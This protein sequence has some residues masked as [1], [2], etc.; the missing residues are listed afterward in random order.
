MNLPFVVGSVTV[1]VIVVLGWPTARLTSRHASAA[2]AT[3]PATAGLAVAV[4]VGLCIL[5]GTSL[6]P[7]LLLIAL[8]G[9]AVYLDARRRGRLVTADDGPGNLALVVAI[10]VALLPVLLVDVPAV[11]SDARY[12]WW[13]HAGWFRH[14]GDVTRSGMTEPL[15]QFSRSR[16]PPVLPGVIA[17]VWHVVDAYGSETALRVSQLFTVAAV[18]AAGFHTAAAARLRG[19]GAA[20]LA[21]V[22]VGVGWGANAQVGLVGFADLAWSSLFVAGAVLLLAGTVERRTEWTGAMFAATAALVK[23]EGQVAAA[24]LLVLVVARAGR[25]WRRAVPAL[26]VVGTAVVGWQVVVGVVGAVP[27]ERGDWGQLVHLLDSDREVHRRLLTTVGH[28]AGELGPLV[29][30][31]AA[32]IVT[33]LLLARWGGIRLR[34]PG[35]LT[36]LAVAS[37]YLVVVALVFAVA[38]EDLGPYL[39]VA[40]YRT[41]IVVR[42]LVLADLALVGVAAA[43]SIGLLAEPPDSTEGTEPVD[44]AAP[45]IIG[46]NNPGRFGSSGVAGDPGT[47]S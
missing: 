36:L 3:A 30:L 23:F 41:V 46:A 14:G 15:F 16:Y 17:V 35:A 24:A 28:L 38:P 13:F 6:V 18:A 33:V 47:A 25:D 26:M 11:E 12:I 43:R 8:A 4:A 7:W 37:L 34:A 2:G 19:R 32:T 20:V 40:A 42:L 9:W 39:D 27:D 31:A 45:P 29:A 21:A 22:V 44:A 5:T 1:L 10:A